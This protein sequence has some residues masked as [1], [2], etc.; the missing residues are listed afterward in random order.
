MSAELQ[1]HLPSAD[2]LL[3]L[4]TVKVDAELLKKQNLRV[5]SQMAVGVDNIDLNA[6]TQRGIP[7]GHT[8]GVLTDA[9]ADLAMLLLL[10]GIPALLETNRDA[11]EGRWGT[12][13]PERWLGADLAGKTLG[14]VGMGAIGQATARRAKARSA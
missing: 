14:I 3:T 2:G 13:Q 4:L 1:R 10:S 5:V 11:R 8:P 7:V 9:T 6:C 12:W